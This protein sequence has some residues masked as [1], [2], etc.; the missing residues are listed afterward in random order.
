MAFAYRNGREWVF[1]LLPLR[2]A[3][4]SIISNKRGSALGSKAVAEELAIT[5]LVISDLRDD[6]NATFIVVTA[7]SALLFLGLRG[8]PYYS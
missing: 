8:S 6:G 5:P 4:P 1:V 2:F 3:P 7:L